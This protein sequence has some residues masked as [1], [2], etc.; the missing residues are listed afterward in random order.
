[1]RPSGLLLFLGAAVL[2]PLA[3]YYYIVGTL[4]QAL[5]A[6][7]SPTVSWSDGPDVE[8]NFKSLAMLN[9]EMGQIVQK[10]SPNAGLV[11]VALAH[12]TK[13]VEIRS[14]GQ[15]ELPASLQ[16]KIETYLQRRGPELARLQTISD[17]P[18]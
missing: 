2:L 12:G 9:R 18:K 1:M 3:C 16:T 4:P 13:T 5:V 8:L 17:Q 6:A 10:D 11:V 14:L 15:K 7:D